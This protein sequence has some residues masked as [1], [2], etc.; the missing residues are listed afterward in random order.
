[1]TLVNRYGQKMLII[2]AG[3]AAQL[4]ACYFKLQGKQN[5]NLV[6]FLDDRKDIKEI[7][8]LPILGPLK[9]IEE[10]I[11]QYQ[12]EQVMFAIPSLH[13]DAKIKVLEACSRT[14]ISAEII[15]DISSVIYGGEHFKSLDKL[16]Y[17]DLLNREEVT[18]DYEKLKPDF[19]LK[20]VLITGAGGSIGSELVRQVIKCEPAE[21]ILLGHGENSIFNIH[22]EIIK[23]SSIPIIPIIADIRDKQRL[24]EVFTLYSP[25][26]VYHAAAHKHV[27]MMEANVYEAVKN[28]ITGTKNLVDV[29]GTS[30]VERFIMISTDKSVDPTSVMGATKKIAEGIVHAKNNETTAGIYSVVRFGNVL[31]S[32]GSAIPLFWKQIK[33]NRTVT[34]THPDM[35]RYFMTIP[36]ASQLVIEAGILAKGKEVFVLKMGEPQ[37][38]TEIVHKLAILAGKNKNQ[39]NVQFIG[40]RNGEKIRE[41]LFE[42]D[43]IVKGYTNHKKF[44]C[45]RAK[46]PKC[47]NK[48]ENWD[49]YFK[50]KSNDEIRNELL[51][52]ANDKYVIEREY[53]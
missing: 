22:Q 25:D 41:E 40:L 42:E 9:D 7:E 14:G 8:G 12:I 6:G 2:G 37:K 28:N 30:C 4:L 15:P 17:R 43:E 26:I 21:I 35:E 24:Q 18:L 47:V 29:S 16:D 11:Y 45:C 50:F 33:A 34:I 48:I 31:G 13:G 49:N 36:E 10:V 38:I 39:L 52:I 19:F 23:K 51:E 1:M 20:R 32:R 44:Y 27:P 5:L 46:I 53:I 3:K